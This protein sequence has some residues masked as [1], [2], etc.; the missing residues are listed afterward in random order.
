MLV[1]MNVSIL[2]LPDIDS[3]NLKFTA[4]FHLSLR[5]Y[6]Y[7]LTFSNL[8][9][10]SIL[11]SVSEDSMNAIWSPVLGFTNALGPY[12]TTVDNLNQLNLVR[13]S[14]PI[15]EDLALSHE[16]YLFPGAN[17][18]IVMKRE[19]YINYACNTFNLVYY[20]FDIQMCSMV[21]EVQ[22]KTD[23]IMK[24][25]KDHDG[26]IFLGKFVTIICN[27]HGKKIISQGRDSWSNTRYSWKSLSLAH[28]KTSAG[29]RSS[30]SSEGESFTTF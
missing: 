8:D 12:Q 16:T 6:D 11:N 23:N 26:V 4:N 28:F 14:N 9:R 29:E 13:E 10:R 27:I 7:R 22:G 2:A 24:L 3:L 30:L 21:F 5:W 20:P 25:V 17:N 19:Y 1:Y 18:S 15:D